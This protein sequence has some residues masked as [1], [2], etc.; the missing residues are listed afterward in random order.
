LTGDRVAEAIAGLRRDGAEALLLS[1]TGMPSLAA[2]AAS[3][4]GIPA[5]SS[6][7]CLAARLLDLIGRHDWLEPGEPAIRGWRWRYDE[8]RRVTPPVPE[9]ARR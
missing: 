8:A 4:A 9:P 7:S 5:I 3:S 2:L 1:G 6:N